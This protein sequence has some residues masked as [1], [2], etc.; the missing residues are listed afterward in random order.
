MTAV[1]LAGRTASSFAAEIG[2]M[3]INQEIDALK[4]MGLNPIQFLT[5]PR[6][7]AT[8]LMTP[9]LS[10]FLILCGLLGCAIVMRTLGYPLDAFLNQLYEAIRIRDCIGGLI[11]VF[12]FGFVIASV[13]CLHGLKTKTGALSVGNSTTQAVVSSIIMMVI[14]DG[15]F[16]LVY[17]ILGI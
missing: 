1:I 11:K 9:I 2:T 15:I 16:A 10:V 7:I 6:V 3:Q 17:Y 4:T 8:T 13:G 5:I 12:A 14:V